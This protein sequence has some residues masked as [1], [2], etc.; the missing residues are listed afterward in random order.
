MPTLRRT[1]LLVA[2]LLVELA[3]LVVLWGLW[4]WE[5]VSHDHLPAVLYGVM[6]LAVPWFGALGGVSNSLYSVSKY[7]PSFTSTDRSTRDAEWRTWSARSLLQPVTGALFAIVA[8]LI[9]VLVTQTVSVETDATG[10]MS[11]TGMAVLATAAFVVGFRQDTFQ[12]LV[13]RAT[14]VIFGPG[15]ELADD[16][17]FDVEPLALDFEGRGRSTVTKKVT[18]T[19]TGSKALPTTATSVHLSHGTSRAFDVGAAGDVPAGGSVDLEVSFHP[20]RLDGASH[21]TGELV[22]SWGGTTKRVRLDGHTPPKALPAAEQQ[23]GDRRR[24]ARRPGPEE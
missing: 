10:E 12:D 16:T 9:V 21:V 13:A 5:V 7:W 17:A 2:G 1:H 20:G 23:G 8:V 24:R 14:E 3:V 4:Q 19:N 18:V 11:R 22:L 15:G 6:P